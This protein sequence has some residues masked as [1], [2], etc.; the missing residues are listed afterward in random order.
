MA[1][2]GEQSEFEH[3]QDA[4]VNSKGSENA[5]EWLDKRALA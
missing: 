5:L 3:T 4:E 2:T 1:A